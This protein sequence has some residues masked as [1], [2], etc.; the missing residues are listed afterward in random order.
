MFPIASSNEEQ[1]RVTSNPQSTGGKPAKLDG[2]FKVTVLSGSGTFTQDEAKP[3]EFVAISGDVDEVIAYELR[4]DALIGE[5]TE[6]IVEIV[7]YTVGAARAATFG[8]TTA[9]EPKGTAGGPA[10]AR[11]TARR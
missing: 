7:E 4:G 2:A 8:L 1:V 10:T 9:V 3:N 5:G 6:E 11:T